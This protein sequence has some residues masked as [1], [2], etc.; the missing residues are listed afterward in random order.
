MFGGCGALPGPA[1]EVYSGRG[2]GRG[3]VA[4]KTGRE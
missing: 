4:K 2:G 1:E 3:R